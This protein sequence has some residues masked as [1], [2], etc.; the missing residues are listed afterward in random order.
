MLNINTYMMYQSSTMPAMTA[1]FRCE[2]F[3]LFTTH[4]VHNNSLILE[5]NINI[6]KNVWH[7]SGTNVNWLRKTKTSN[8]VI[9]NGTWVKCH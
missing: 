8:A 1:I 4:T 9:S 6:Y 3:R 7:K 5:K 2:Y